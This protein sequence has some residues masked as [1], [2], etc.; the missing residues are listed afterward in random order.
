MLAAPASLF[1][2]WLVAIETDSHN[3]VWSANIVNRY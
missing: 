2:R 1:I 3:I